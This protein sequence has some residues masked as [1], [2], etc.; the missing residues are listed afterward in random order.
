[1]QTNGLPV[2]NSNDHE[3][4]GIKGSKLGREIKLFK[5]KI[6]PTRLNSFHCPPYIALDISSTGS[7]PKW[8]GTEHIAVTYV[9]R[10]QHEDT[11]RRAARAVRQ[12]H[13]SPLHSWGLLSAE[14][15]DNKKAHFCIY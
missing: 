15:R 9:G 4:K 14:H 8:M 7:F 3:R 12:R 6:Y 5:Y 1:M 11:G 10:G 13:S 2:Y